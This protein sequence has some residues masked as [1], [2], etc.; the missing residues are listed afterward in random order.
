MAKFLGLNVNSFLDVQPFENWPVERSVDDDSDPPE[1]RFVFPDCGLALIC[2]R[3]D[4]R[5][6]TIFLEAEKYAGTVLSEVSFHLGRDEVHER[7]GSPSKRG[8]AMS[9]P[10]L[11]EYGPWDRFDGPNYTVHIQFNVDSD[12]IKMITLMRND[13]VP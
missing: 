13:V 10:I 11:G 5:I 4:E 12:S 9:D 1:V 6:N 8:N 3:E 7:F 2:D